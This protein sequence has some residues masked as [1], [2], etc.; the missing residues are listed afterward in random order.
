MAA[1]AKRAADK[2]LK[3]GEYAEPTIDTG[4]QSAA[5]EQEEAASTPESAADP[6]D[7]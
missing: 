5:A 7:P 3:R 1:K 6:N 4:K 2:V